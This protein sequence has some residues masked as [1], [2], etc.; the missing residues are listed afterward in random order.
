MNESLQAEIIQMPERQLMGLKIETNLQTNQTF[1]LWRQ[2]MPWRQQYL[3][4]LHTEVFAVQLYDA[5]YFEYFDVSNTFFQWACVEF[6]NGLDWPSSF[7]PLTIPAGLYAVF[8][9]KGRSDDQ[10]IFNRI[11]TE[12]LPTSKYAL[13]DRP[14]VQVMGEHYR[15]MD[16]NSEEMIYIPVRLKQ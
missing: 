15:N 16:P 6:Q 3:T 9:Y 2:L 10:S 4:V 13:D 5:S 14:H 11:F 12:W 1:Q 8:L 7:E